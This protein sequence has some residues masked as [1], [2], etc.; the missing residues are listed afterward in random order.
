MDED[1][2]VGKGGREEGRK[3]KNPAPSAL[4]EGLLGVQEA[5]GPGRRRTMHVWRRNCFACKKFHQLIVDRCR[6]ARVYD[7]T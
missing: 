2:L 1:G 7:G 3:K 5:C 6:S 4:N